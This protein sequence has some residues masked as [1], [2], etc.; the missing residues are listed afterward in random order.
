MPANL[1]SGDLL[2]ALDEAEVGGRW[3]A[4][5]RAI[6]SWPERL[7]QALGLAE[8]ARRPTAKGPASLTESYRPLSRARDAR[9]A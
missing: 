4:L 5:R 6:G 1:A 9:K 2:K 7:L 3:F 8:G